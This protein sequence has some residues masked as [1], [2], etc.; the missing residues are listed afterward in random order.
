MV[1]SENLI[2]IINNKITKYFI[3]YIIIVFEFLQI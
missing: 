1:F 3:I 2:I